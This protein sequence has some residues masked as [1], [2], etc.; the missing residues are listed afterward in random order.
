MKEGNK[1]A[2]GMLALSIAG[3]L[4]KIIS[5]VYTPV[6]REILGDVGYGMYSQTT[7][8]FVFVYA[9]ACMG[10]QPAVAKVVSELTAVGNEEGANRALKISRKLFG[11]ISIILALIMVALAPIVAN[12]SQTP[13]IS[14]GLF[15]LAPCVVITAL[16]STY[17]G[18]MQ[19]KS[20]MT[21]IAIS[22]IIE[23]I[24][25]VIFS[26]L[27]A[28]ILVK[29]SLAFG[30]AGAQV[31]TSL[32]ALCACLFLI[33]TYFKDKYKEN[34]KNE[35]NVRKISDKRI[36]QK[37]IRY[38][39]P[40]ILSA[41]L[42]NLG[43]VID[44]LNV[45]NRLIFIGFSTEKA[46]IL[47]GHLGLY[48]TLYG[49]PLVVITAIGIAVLPALSKS[50]A[51]KEKKEARSKIRKAFKLIYIIAI[52]A[53]IGFAMASDYI[54]LSLFG[55]TN[56]SN[57]MKFG[58][59][60]II[61]MATTQLQS[62]VLQSINKFYYMLGTFMIGIAFKIAL[63]Y[64]FV[65]IPNINIYGVLIGN[66]FWHMI[67]AILNH[68]KICKTMRM[69]MP[70]IRVVFKPIVSSLIMAIVIY[71]IGIPVGVMY[72]FI[73][74]SRYTSIPILTIILL[75]AGFVY[76]YTMILSGGIKK[77]DIE[78]I[79][80]KIIKVLPRFMRIKLR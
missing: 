17:R 41:G 7:K 70:L 67:P 62:I 3:I 16:L 14:Y 69:K 51:L 22:Q 54:Y 71:I 42:Q 20:N 6:L 46:D 5:V 10:A 48:E 65:G 64:L 34:G 53:S 29:V 12:K 4:V 15:A 52:P 37:L 60:I 27:C 38:S 73:E 55:T 23:Q 25:N 31:G 63:N 36:L 68:K 9:V 47:Y 13:E 57:I 11:G 24:I 28:F 80:P 32:G 50:I 35:D 59:F 77:A 30:N 19:G 78:S 79:S 43:G 2:R 40:I 66:F 8:I 45:K 44:L 75:I 74:P 26:L 18:F 21:S 1:T 58:S 33:H 76:L 49:V 56:G 72:R 39:F 61:L